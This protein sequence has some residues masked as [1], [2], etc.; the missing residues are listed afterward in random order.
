[1]QT[2]FNHRRGHLLDLEREEEEAALAAA[3]IA[4]EDADLGTYC[5]SVP[6]TA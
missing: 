6:Y 3:A 2:K 5:L 1:V 4:A